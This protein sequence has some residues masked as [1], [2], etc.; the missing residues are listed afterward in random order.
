MI[1]RLAATL[2][3]PAALLAQNPGIPIYKEGPGTKPEAAMRK[4][5][6]EMR[7]KKALPMGI[8]EVAEQLARTS[9]KLTL[10]TPSKKPLDARERWGMARSNHVR[11][12]WFY[13]APK[14]AAWQIN[15]SGGYA[16]SADGAV[17]TC[18]HVVLPVAH[19][20]REGFLFVTDDD[21]H[22]FPV[23]EVLAASRETDCC[24]LR[25]KGGSFTPLPLG[26]D[27]Q[28]GDTVSCFSDPMGH[29]GF[30]SEGIVN[31]FVQ[32]RVIGRQK[33]GKS[34]SEAATWLEAST[35]WAPGSSGSAVLDRFGNILAHVA[36]IESVPED[37]PDPQK[38]PHLIIP[39]T[40]IIFHDAVLSKHVRDLIK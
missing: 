34:K 19:E 7:E 38:E 40:V 14:L 30:Y 24:I 11:V 37:Q 15:L 39:G 36:E 18:F 12:G 29:R 1:R 22:I 23:T 16:I 10:P 9:C 20:M 21:D 13:K 27:V 25:V 31:R 5:L 2:L 32:R 26:S 8:D 3:F 4:E 6:T 17:A 35:D 33:G 28:P